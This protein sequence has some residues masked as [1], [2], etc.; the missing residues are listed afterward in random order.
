MS[1]PRT[2]RA[3]AARS[4][5]WLASCAREAALPA[6]GG[7]A[8]MP[9]RGGGGAGRGINTSASPANPA[10]TGP[11][12]CAGNSSR[13][14]YLSGSS[15]W[16]S[17]SIGTRFSPRTWRVRPVAMN[18]LTA[19]I[20]ASPPSAA[21]AAA[22]TL[23]AVRPCASPARDRRRDKQD[24]CNNGE[25]CDESAHRRRLLRRTGY[26]DPANE[27]RLST[28]HVRVRATAVLRSGFASDEKGRPNVRP[29]GLQPI[30]E[31]SLNV[32]RLR[33]ASLWS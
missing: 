28:L 24:S 30:V 22:I 10:V 3:S 11:A 19:A 29:G 5:A 31:R 7:G 17:N 15:A 8:G 4:P 16:I 32:V 9:G 25:N 21:R 18:V 2:C 27:K 26:L 20:L 1:S 13:R 14:E 12:S 33:S 6:P 23:S